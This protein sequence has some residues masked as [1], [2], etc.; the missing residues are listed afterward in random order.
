MEKLTDL[1]T[2]IDRCSKCGNCQSVCPLYA[3]E[4]RETHVARGKIFLLDRLTDGQ[5]RW[6]KRLQEVMST[7]L[8][9]R[10]CVTNCPNEVQA[11]RLIRAAREEAGS[12]LGLSFWKKSAFHFLLTSGGRLNLLARLLWVYERSGIQ[13]L[14]RSSGLLGQLP[15]GLAEKESALPRAASRAF[16]SQV[17]QVVTAHTPRMRVAYFYGCMTN[18]A[19][20]GTGHSTVRVLTQNGASVV[21]PRQLCCGLPALAS[22]DRG[23]AERLARE[24]IRL[25]S[26]TPFDYVVTDCASCG[27]MLKEYGELLGDGAAVPFSAKVKDVTELLA[28]PLGFTPGPVPFRAKITYHDPCHLKRYQGIY[29]QPRALLSAVQGISFTEM[30]HADACCGS[31]GSFNITH[32]RLSTAVGGQKAANV[33]KSGA[34]SVATG[35]PACRLQ[36]ER[37]L[38]AAGSRI[39]VL[40]TV[41]VLASTYGEV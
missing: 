41:D 12:T 7:C 35:C 39:S 25:L 34:E 29:T 31:A 32:Y 30:K 9:C 19:Y 37:C 17:P 33:M 5:T 23:T 21:L 10:T 14:V 36:I 26:Q 13:K 1:K 28:G 38:K 15:W 24:N 11:E 4:K 8:L 27:S 6:T 22:G 16:S 18:H 3:V 40:H 2:Q 20:T